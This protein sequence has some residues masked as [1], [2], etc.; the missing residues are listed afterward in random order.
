M[1]QVPENAALVLEGGSMRALF[2][3]G[4]LDVWMEEG[5]E[6]PCVAGVSAGA[7]CGLNY[8]S[9]Q[10]GRSAKINLEFAGDKRYVGLNN[11]VKNGSIF[12]FDFLFGE[13]S[14]TL[15][16]FDYD[17]F[18]ASP[19]RFTAVSTDCRTAE[20]V[21]HEKGVSQDILLASRASAS[22]PLLAPVVEVDG[23]P[24]LDGA[25]AVSIPVGWAMAEGYE[26]IVLVLTRQR[27][28]RKKPTSR[29]LS[30]AYDHAY[31]RQ[32]PVLTARLKTMPERY[33]ALQEKIDDWEREGRLFV[34]RPA[35][36]VTVSRVE[37]DRDKLRALYKK[38]RE[39]ARAQMDALEAYLTK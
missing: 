2:T 32:Y 22:M 8:V 15:L 23:R 17:A 29:A 9:H 12:N 20:P 27:G 33:N 7:M 31:R 36:P 5:V 3:A 34:L 18:A 35:E 10:P 38:G 14:Q 37:T 21:Y 24:C 11:Y 4:V 16:P 28:F 19:K 6:F 13:V 26:K 1:I 30:R 25:G 39:E